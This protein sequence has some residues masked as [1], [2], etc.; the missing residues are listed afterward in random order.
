MFKLLRSARTVR[1]GRDPGGRRARRCPRF[2]S[3]TKQVRC[4][5]SRRRALAAGLLIAFAFADRQSL[6]GRESV[7]PGDC[8]HLEHW[9]ARA[10][11]AISIGHLDEAAGLLEQVTTCRPDSGE[12]W[13]RLGTIEY[14]RG[15]YEHALRAFRRLT[16]LW[17]GYGPA[18]L[19]TGLTLFQQ[20]DYERAFEEIQRANRLGV[21]DAKIAQ[22]GA[23]YEVLSLVVL[24]RFEQADG[25]LPWII[26]AEPE[27]PKIHELVGMTVL[28]I[29]S[30][31]GDL[32]AVRREMARR[33]GR[34]VS[35][36][37]MGALE[38]ARLEFEGFFRKFR[39]VPHAHYVFGVLL[40][41]LDSDEA[42]KEFEA[43]LERDPAH[44]PSLL[45]LALEY[46]RRNQLES[47]QHYAEKSLT[48]APDSPAATSILGQIKLE[49]GDV[50][51]GIHFLERAVRLAPEHPKL[52]LLLAQAYAR[53]RR[54]EEANREREIYERLSEEARA[55]G[56]APEAAVEP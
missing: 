8:D 5:T 12:A 35:L 20:G 28:R 1:R 19:F 9:Q 38:E 41:Q 25:F 14:D 32:D 51:T 36:G 18:H 16:E 40:L 30:L 31:P 27:N 50:E 34:A 46:K 3:R 48:V 54:V 22:L 45:R 49:Q 7:P 44:L 21:E 52:H 6:M 55:R 11:E 29:A 47:A 10:S 37:Q 39:D 13:W 17:P 42:V 24:S 23:Y 33:I 43:E 15:E 4:S 2:L 26:N 53:A 56:E